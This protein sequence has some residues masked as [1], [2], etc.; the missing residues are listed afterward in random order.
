MHCHYTGVPQPTN[1]DAS[2]SDGDLTVT[3]VYSDSDNTDIPLQFIQ[4]VRF[5]YTIKSGSTTTTS[6]TAGPSERK[7]TVD[8]SEYNYEANT[9]YN[10][11]LRAENLLGS[12]TVADTQF[13]TPSKCTT[14]CI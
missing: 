9:R 1:I 13:T 11:E 5:L 7:F 4:V 12:S 10:L 2:I 6:G 8:L 3:W 14:P